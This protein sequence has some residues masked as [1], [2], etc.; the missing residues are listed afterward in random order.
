MTFLAAHFGFPWFQEALAIA[1]HKSNVWIELS[2]WA[3]KYLPPEV[4]REAGKRLNDRTVFGSDYPFISLERWFAEAEDLPW[5]PEA[6]QA[7]LVERPEAAGL[8]RPADASPRP[9]QYPHSFAASVN[10]MRAGTA[11][12]EAARSTG[13]PASILRAR[14]IGRRAC[15]RAAARTAARGSR[16]PDSHSAGPS[17]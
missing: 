12:C 13:R 4:V 5:S 1:L 10:A 8:S 14:A 3:P 11:I 16:R 6:R 7:I 9:D 2:G 15:H 17:V